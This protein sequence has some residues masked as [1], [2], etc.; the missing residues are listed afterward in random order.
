ML[1]RRVSLLCNTEKGRLTQT[2]HRTWSCGCLCVR[3][4]HAWC[5]GW[6][7]CKKPMLISLLGTLLAIAIV[8]MKPYV[9][10]NT[11]DFVVTGVAG[12]LH[13]ARRMQPC[14]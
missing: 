13:V 8:A 7:K 11:H 5:W 10:Q 2:G 12:S 9:Q 6:A 14:G 1:R 4:L 3:D